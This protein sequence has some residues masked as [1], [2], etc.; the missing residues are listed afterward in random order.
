[1]ISPSTPYLE[2]GFGPLAG[3]NRFTRPVQVLEAH[4]LGEVIPVI[5]QAEAATRNGLYAAG[6]V[7][8]DAAPAFEAAF[9]VQPA[10]DF[11]L[12]WF[13][14]FDGPTPSIVD[15]PEGVA[16]D[17]YAS[18][19][20]LLEWTINRS[21]QEFAA[22]IARI[23]E[24]IA[25]G[26]VYQVNHTVRMRSDFHGDGYAWWRNLCGSTPAPYS[27]YLHLGR[28]EILSLSPELFFRLENDC[29]TAR[30]MK[31]TRPRGRW[32]GEDRSLADELRNSTKDRAENLMIVD[33]L[34]ND[35]GRV[36]AFGSVRV[37]RLFEIE[38]YPTVHQM[39][40]TISAEARPDA[41]YADLF[42]AL[43]PCGSVTGAPKISA[44]RM[45]SELEP[46]PRQVYCGAIGIMAPGRRCVFN[47]AIRTILV[48]HKSE[49]AVYGSG[50]GITW[51]SNAEEEYAEI[52]V[53]AAVLRSSNP[54]FELLET[55]RLEEGV[56][57][58]E[59][60]H[61]ERACASA[62]YFGIPL[63]RDAL[64]VALAQFAGDHQTGTWRVRILISRDAAIRFERTP[65]ALHPNATYRARLAQSPV[66]S[67]DRFLYHKTTNRSVYTRHRASA[68]ELDEV[69]LWNERGELTEFTTGNL[70]VTMGGARYT[71]PIACG[72]LAGTLRAELLERGEITERI[73]RREELADCEEI[74][75]INSVRD[76]IPVTLVDA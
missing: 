23:R 3:Q 60:R 61:V 40:S 56:F 24:A 50:G 71:P 20:E 37:D 70:V 29:L 67:Q 49:T 48:D 19:Q 14:I 65:L 5:E 8:Y 57:V 58:L 74:W 10:G 7:S 39:T 52:Q 63:E 26:T 68:P 21:P 64:E 46:D 51:D 28:F 62:E 25:A 30:P 13:G 1:M 38:R 66:S 76:W 6:Y 59:R 43:F 9:A 12:A 4:S 11:P 73:L 35:L 17:A 75:F 45:I 47:V 72:V 2:F 15:H 32:T 55:L 33:L 34:R 36:A 16:I 69:L 53:K 18:E 54:T 41:S 27:A 22:E 31:G 44:V 42:R